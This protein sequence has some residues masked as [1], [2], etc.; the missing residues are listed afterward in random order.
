MSF[1]EQVKKATPQAPVITIVGFAGSGKSSLAGLFP[2]PIFIQA[3]NATSVFETVS[4]DLQP[5]FFPQL[6]IPNAK[7]NIKTSDVLLEQLRELV[8]QDHEFKTV[9][10]DTVTALNILFEQEVID[11][12]EKGAS[13]RRIGQMVICGVSPFAAIMAPSQSTSTP[14]KQ[15][16]SHSAHKTRLQSPLFRH[17][18]CLLNDAL[19]Q[20][21]DVGN[22]ASLRWPGCWV[23]EAF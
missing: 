22:R 18:I 7:R 15:F 8:T 5:A 3:E 13:M 17:R 19:Q 11:F 14:L 1:L 2:N 6:P 9:V 21:F 16:E 23:A 10:I 12:D 20:V 4:D